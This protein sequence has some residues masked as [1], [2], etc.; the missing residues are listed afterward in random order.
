M[1]Y[2][3]II[4][5]DQ[6]FLLH[7][8][9]YQA[10]GRGYLCA[11]GN[12]RIIIGIKIRHFTCFSVMKYETGFH[13]P[14]ILVKEPAIDQH[15]LCYNKLSGFA[16]HGTGVVPQEKDHSLRFVVHFTGEDSIDFVVR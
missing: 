5:F 3:N 7:N 2:V 10:I 11:A 6:I 1:E 16:G 8:F 13:L 15:V 9:V 12:F 4:V 14:G